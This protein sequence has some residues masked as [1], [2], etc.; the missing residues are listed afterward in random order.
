[1]SNNGKSKTSDAIISVVF[2][3]WFVAS[4]IGMVYVAK[5]GRTALLLAIFGQYFFVFGI[6]GLISAISDGGFKPKHV[7]ILLFPLVGAG[8]IAGGFIIQYGSK[9]LKE[10]SLAAV[11]FIFIILFAVIGVGLI[12]AGLYLCLYLKLVCREYVNAECIEVLETRNSHGGT[13]W[14]P[15]YSYYYNGQY[16]K[17][18]NDVY[19][20]TV[21][22]SVGQQYELY[23]NANNPMQFYEPHNSRMTGIYMIIFGFFILLFMGFVMH[24]IGKN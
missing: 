16:Y 14:C 11:P 20:N 8:A 10:K 12:I 4:I 6:I 3:I 19:T 17:V 5:T 21:Y 13:A 9:D 2:L 7:P 1:M 22:P 15:V 24:M 18:S 23:I